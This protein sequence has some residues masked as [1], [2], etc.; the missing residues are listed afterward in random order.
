MHCDVFNVHITL[1]VVTGKQN[2]YFQAST[3]FFEHILKLCSPIDMFHLISDSDFIYDWYMIGIHL[4]EWEYLATDG[5]LLEFVNYRTESVAIYD[6]LF[7]GV[8]S[9]ATTTDQ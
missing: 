2:V 5:T 7:P 3:L 8:V 1:K 9:T 4:K 6:I